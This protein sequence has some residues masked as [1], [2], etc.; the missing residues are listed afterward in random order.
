MKEKIISKNLLLTLAFL[1]GGIVMCIELLGA[2]FIAP[3]YGSSLEVWSIVLAVSVGA[4]TCG[5]FAGGYF[6]G[7][8]N[9]SILLQLFLILAGILILF[10]PFLAK[11][12]V[13]NYNADNLIFDSFK[14]SLIFLAP[15]LFFLGSTTP[16]IIELKN[17]NQ[18]EIGKTSGIVYGTS[19]FGGIFFTYL[20][21]FYLIPNYGLTST[22]MVAGVLITIVPFCVL[23]FEKKYLYL[24]LVPV[25]G[26]SFYLNQTSNVINSEFTILDYSEGLLGQLLLVDINNKTS[27]E[28]ALFVNRIG[29]TWVNSENGQTKWDYPNYLVTLAS[30]LRE[31]P[32]VLVLGLGGG[33]V[34]R[35]LESSLNAKIEAVE[36]DKR[37]EAIA[38]NYF[39][40][41][42]TK[43]I[44]DDARHFIEASHRKYDLIVFD[45]YKGESPPSHTLS[46]EAFTKIKSML[47]ENGMCVINFNGFIHGEDGKAGRSLLKTLEAV[48][49]STVIIPTPG[50][51]NYRNCLYVA[52]IKKPNFNNAKFP[53]MVNGKNISIDSLA[54]DFK[55]IDMSDAVIL[56]DDK[57]ILEKLNAEAS[58]KWR[59]AYF[60]NFTNK[61]TKEGVSIFK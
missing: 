10:M 26:L 2:R 6:A 42:N 1:E 41:G 20:T 21:G 58:K 47:M 46:I 61:M 52:A 23:L 57:P 40:L 24:S 56:T 18:N 16:L 44:I 3:T 55:I 38:R 9:K 49:F 4:L 50:E 22:A 29:Q 51:D 48:G 17:V 37:M 35:Y 14:A 7:S 11:L 27:K 45:L 30:T 19:T 28:R 43:V 53:L 59:E 39:S 15:P 33:T 8:K 5:Y 60:N 32:N 36:I 13:T 25:F 34:P 12:I 31:K 54:I